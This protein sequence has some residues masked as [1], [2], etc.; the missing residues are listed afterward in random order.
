MRHNKDI[1]WKGLLE[2]VFDDLLRFVFPDADKVFDMRRA[3]AFL[4][5]ELAEMYPEPEK[6][7]DVRVVDKLV[8]VFRKDGEEEWVLVHIEIQDKTKARDRALFPE[9]MF[10]YFYRCLDRYRKPVA[11]IAIYTGPDGKRLPDCYEY[12]FMRTNLKYQYNTLCILDCPD[13]E[14]GRSD[15]PF[16]WV[17][18]AAKKALLKGKDLDKKLLAGKLFVFRKLYEGGIFERKKLQAI[19]TFLDNYV[20]FEKTESNRIFRKEIDK[21]T[22]KKNTMDI[23]EQVAEWRWQE[24]LQEG[25]RK[26]INEGLEKS[27]RALLANTEF[28]VEKIASLIGVSVTR[29]RKLS[30]EVRCK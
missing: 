16:A 5:K 1:L 22:G 9:R 28:S 6:E 27:V 7:S 4:D 23:F 26:G 30:K 14:L 25:H 21:I 24:G 12:Q 8:K 13:E 11:A 3:F 18:L 20:R 19:L 15:N 17:V 2:W 29:V 10:R